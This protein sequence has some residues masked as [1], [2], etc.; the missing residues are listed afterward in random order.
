[1]NKVKGRQTR[2]AQGGKRQATPTRCGFGCG[3]SRKHSLPEKSGSIAASPECGAKVLLQHPRLQHRCPARRHCA[4]LILRSSLHTPRHV[5]HSCSSRLQG[6]RCRHAV[7]PTL[8]DIARRAPRRPP[9]A[10]QPFL[11]S[12]GQPTDISTTARRPSLPLSSLSP[13]TM[14]LSVR[15]RAV[16]SPSATS[17]RSPR[18]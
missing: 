16:S 9:R 1:M 11:Q 8:P 18:P 7:C 13:P 12:Q 14:P 2:P 4:S 6:W 15:S 17:R 5:V 10:P 3:C